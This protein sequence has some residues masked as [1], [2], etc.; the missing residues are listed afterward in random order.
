MQWTHHGPL[1]ASHAAACLSGTCQRPPD[2]LRSVEVGTLAWRPQTQ[3]R[4]EW[5][6]EQGP[7]EQFTCSVLTPTASPPALPGLQPGYTTRQ[8]RT[9]RQ[10]PA[11]G[12]RFK[13]SPTI[14]HLRRASD[15]RWARDPQWQAGK[16]TWGHRGGEKEVPELLLMLRAKRV[17]TKQ[18]QN[19]LLK[20]RPREFPLWLS[21]LKTRLVS[22]RM[23][24]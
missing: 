10:L 14:R 15:W 4:P 12:P 11:S 19:A 3:L 21:G 2:C 9:P 24:V 13:I 23:Q 1:C 7:E 18:E 16:A 20:R 8:G 5:P 22:M 6:P 17:P